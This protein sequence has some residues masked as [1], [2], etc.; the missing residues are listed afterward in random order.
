M[1]SLLDRA[2]FSK[3]TQSR[4]ENG[5]SEKIEGLYIVWFPLT[6][7]CNI[8]SGIAHHLGYNASVVSLST[9]RLLLL[10]KTCFASKDYYHSKIFL[11]LIHNI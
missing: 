11:S 9:V 4:Q 1:C 2:V 10:P 5:I 8:G 6:L 3:T 7:L